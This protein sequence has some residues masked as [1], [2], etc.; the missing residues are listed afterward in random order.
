MW[1]LHCF[2]LWPALRGKERGLPPLV[3]GLPACECYSLALPSSLISRN[4]PF[5]SASGPSFPVIVD[6][7]ATIS[8]FV[9]PPV[10]TEG[11]VLEGITMGLTIEGSGT[12]EWVLNK[13]Q[14]FHLITYYVPKVSH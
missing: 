6:L 11:A 12:V 7:G 3:F 2:F 5:T 14:T 10:T 4:H 9:T 1:I 13:I 8:D